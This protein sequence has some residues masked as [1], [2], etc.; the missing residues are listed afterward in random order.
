MALKGRGT[1][2]VTCPAVTGLPPVSQH[3][4]EPTVRADTALFKEQR[5][6]WGDT[7]IK[8]GTEVRLAV[9]HAAGQCFLVFWSF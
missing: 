8:Q 2:Q 3:H 1:Y 4:H 9:G 5:I 7:K 6:N